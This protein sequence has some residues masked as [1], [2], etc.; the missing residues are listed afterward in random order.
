[1]MRRCGPKDRGENYYR[2]GI[3]VCKRWQNYR[4]FLEDMGAPP[5]GTRISIDRIDNDGN[6]EPGNCRWATP[7]EQQR[8][9]RT[10]VRITRNG[11]TGMNRRSPRQPASHRALS[12]E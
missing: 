5:K 7:K 9:K 8:N 2:R 1:M 12:I 3:R 6:Y 10:N 11:M 4:N